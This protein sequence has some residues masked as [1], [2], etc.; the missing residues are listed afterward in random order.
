M[1]GWVG[2]GGEGEGGEGDGIWWCLRDGGLGV[3]IW[4]DLVGFAE[5]G[6][7]GEGRCVAVLVAR[8]CAL[9]RICNRIGM[10]SGVLDI[11]RLWVQSL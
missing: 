3:A 4:L 8:E 2:G 11:W 6:E 10:V 1:F 7:L 5:F 9:W